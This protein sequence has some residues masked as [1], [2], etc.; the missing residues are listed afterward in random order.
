[1]TFKELMRSSPSM[2]DKYMNTFIHC[3]SNNLRIQEDEEDLNSCVNSSRELYATKAKEVFDEFQV[4]KKGVAYRLQY[5]SWPAL[6][7]LQYAVGCSEPHIKKSLGEQLKFGLPGGL[8]EELAAAYPEIRKAEHCRSLGFD[9]YEIF[10]SP[11]AQSMDDEDFFQETMK[12]VGELIG[13]D[14][15]LMV[16]FQM[17][18]MATQPPGA[19]PVVKAIQS[20]QVGVINRA[21]SNMTKII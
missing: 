9:D 16:A 13:D 7:C 10:T 5:T 17:L 18:L 14:E 6:P 1:M 8:Y 3:F 11:W 19:K 2:M 12:G 15:K 20:I 4:L 21:L